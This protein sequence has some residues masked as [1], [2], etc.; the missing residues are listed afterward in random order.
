MRA[1]PSA[2]SKTQLPPELRR[3]LACESHAFPG[4]I[5]A[6]STRGKGALGPFFISSDRCYQKVDTYF[7]S[8]WKHCSPPTAVA[9]VRFLD[10][11]PHVG[12]VCSWFSFLLLG[13]SLGSPVFLPPQKST[14]LNSN[15][16]WK[17]WMKS[18]FLKMSL[19]IPIYFIYL[20]YF[21]N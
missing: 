17:Q 9:R 20:F 8:F 11:A 10:P 18:H 21:F 7:K 13:F 16:F 19:H 6:F 1:T 15:S 3:V 2:F 4:C 12:W 14:L 5:P